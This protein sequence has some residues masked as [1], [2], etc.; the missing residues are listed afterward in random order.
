MKPIQIVYFADF[1]NWLEQTGS[2]MQDTRCVF[3]TTTETY[4]S[5]RVS[6]RG[7]DGAL[8]YHLERGGFAVVGK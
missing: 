1:P 6:A 7:P 2:I 3:S 5:V 4:H 8:G